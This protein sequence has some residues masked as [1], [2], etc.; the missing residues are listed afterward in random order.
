MEEFNHAVSELAAAESVLEA[1]VEDAPKTL[2]QPAQ[3]SAPASMTE[4]EA[5]EKIKAF[6]RARSKKAAAVMARR[7]AEREE[8]NQARA[9]MGLPPLSEKRGRR[10]AMFRITRDN[11]P[12]FNCDRSLMVADL[13]DFRGKLVWCVLMAQKVKYPED[14]S[15]WTM[16]LDPRRED[17]A[18]IVIRLLP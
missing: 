11:D 15:K 3:P 1:A 13:G 18:N 7:R 10:P 17:P 16:S 8:E 12:P 14:P 9:V 6:T 5:E 2:A 4:A